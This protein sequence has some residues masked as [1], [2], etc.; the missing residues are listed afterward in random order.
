MAHAHSLKQVRTLWR[1]HLQNATRGFGT[2]PE[3]TDGLY[4]VVHKKHAIITTY[5]LYDVHLCMC[6]IFG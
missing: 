3:V 2:P 5:L 1:K 4:T 6:A